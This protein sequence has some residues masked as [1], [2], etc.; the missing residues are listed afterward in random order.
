MRR[1]QTISCAVLLLFIV[2]GACA[3]DYVWINPPVKIIVLGSSTAAGY[4]ASSK[5]SSWV[6][7]YA[8]Y[9]QKFNPDNE[10]INLAVGGY[11]SYHIM[12]DDFIPPPR[13]RQSD[14]LANISKALSL[15]CDGI[16]VNLP[17]NDIALGFSVK[18]QLDNLKRV[19]QEAENDSVPIWLCTVQPRN[20]N[21]HN[22]RSQQVEL[23]DSIVTIFP[24]RVIDFWTKFAS[25]AAGLVEAYDSGD[26]CHLNDEGHRLLTEYVIKSNAFDSILRC[27]SE[28]VEIPQPT[29]QDPQIRRLE[30]TGTVTFENFAPFQPTTLEVIQFDTVVATI[31]LSDPNYSIT[32]DIYTYSK[33]SLHFSNE[34]SLTKSLYFDFF[35][36][37]FRNIQGIDKTTTI[38]DVNVSM[39]LLSELK[40]TPSDHNFI[41]AE[42]G[43]RDNTAGVELI[44]Q[45]DLGR[46]QIER[47]EYYRNPIR[48]GVVKRYYSNGDL[49][50]KL[51]Y[52]HAQ[53]HGKCVWY[54][55]K[56]KRRHVKARFRHG[57]YDGKFTEYAINGNK[58]YSE[59]R[60]SLIK[61]DIILR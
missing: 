57:N 12:P 56:S 54:Y 27:S 18:E 46:L 24:D 53:L 11:H 28:K 35:K 52:K 36:F 32:I 31:T 30:F 39:T 16:I 3:Q 4:G 29:L 42:Y 9:L 50:A 49:F 34:N 48:K 26:G 15:N 41:A 47:L 7:R 2:E 60:P 59:E 58:I 13:R 19:V 45:E 44:Y 5:D 1:I 55:P 20:F 22:Q 10:V 17:S 21:R 37:Y 40:E 61:S 23:Y 25:P 38:E 43:L 14:S 6:R 51:K 8:A 33:F